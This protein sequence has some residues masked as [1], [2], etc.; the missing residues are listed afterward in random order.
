MLGLTV[1]QVKVGGMVA[2]PLAIAAAALGVAWDRWQTAGAAAGRGEDDL[3]VLTTVFHES[4]RTIRRWLTREFIDDSIRNLLAASLNSERLARSYWEQAISPF[5]EESARGFKSAWRYQVDLIDLDCD[6][7]LSEGGEEFATFAARDYRALRTSVSYVQ[8]IADPA[9]LY[10]VAAVFSERDLPAWFTKPNFLLREVIDAP[11]G[12]AQHLADGAA[13]AALPTTLGTLPAPSATDPRA[14]LARR[15]LDA[16]VWFGEQVREPAVLH[17][18][19]TGVSWG[20]HF[21]EAAREALR[22]GCSI[23]VEIATY[24]PRAQRS[25]PVVIAAPTRNPTIEFSYGRTDID[26]VQ[27]D[28]FFSAARPWDS[29]LRTD[30]ADCRRIEVITEPDDWVFAG[31]G[32]IFRW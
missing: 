6:V 27:A 5:L 32:C 10:Y 18:D 22:E 4:P 13:P 17:I 24:V 9:E 23:R 7:V 21:D 14:M 30:G 20:F 19:E 1:A 2:A 8:R 15:L 29:R 26:K 12:L 11:I 31:S 16:R 3:R 28:V 25:F